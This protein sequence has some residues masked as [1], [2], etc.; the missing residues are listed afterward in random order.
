MERRQFLRRLLSRGRG[1]V[2]CPLP[3]SSGPGLKRKSPGIIHDHKD[4]ADRVLWFEDGKLKEARVVFHDPV[5]GMALEEFNIA[6]S[7]CTRAERIISVSRIA[8]ESVSEPRGV[9]HGAQGYLCL[10]I[11]IP[12]G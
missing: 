11:A 4:I 5:C 6:R 8:S 1:Q 9:H 10:N 7:W 3:P 12:P 2:H